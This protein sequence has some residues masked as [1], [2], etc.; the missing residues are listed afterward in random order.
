M[1][2]KDGISNRWGPDGLFHKQ[3]D[4]AE[5]LE[6]GKVRFAVRTV[7]HSKLQKDRGSRCGTKVTRAHEGNEGGTPWTLG[8]L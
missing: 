2:D 1:Q 8:I 5:Q 3:D 7:H 6:K 4:W